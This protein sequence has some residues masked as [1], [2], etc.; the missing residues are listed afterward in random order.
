MMFLFASRRGCHEEYGL[1]PLLLIIIDGSLSILFVPVF[2]K[3]SHVKPTSFK[4]FLIQFMWSADKLEGYF[5]SEHYLAVVAVMEYS[6]F[7]N[8]T[9]LMCEII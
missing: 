6:Q 4:F 7:E 1:S 3:Y 8:L 9:Q 2:Y 5:S